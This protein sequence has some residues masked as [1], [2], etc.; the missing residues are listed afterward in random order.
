MVSRA[1][2][3]GC[4][5][6]FFEKMKGTLTRHNCQNDTAKIGQAQNHGPPH[7][8]SATVVTN[9]LVT[10]RALNV[11]AG[12][13]AQLEKRRID[14][15]GR[16]TS[17]KAPLPLSSLMRH[18][19]FPTKQLRVRFWSTHNEPATRDVLPSS[20]HPQRSSRTTSSTDVASPPQRATRRRS[21]KDA[22]NARGRRACNN[23]TPPAN[24]SSFDPVLQDERTGLSFSAN[25]NRQEPGSLL[26][27]PTEP[28]LPLPTIRNGDTNV[29][30]IAKCAPCHKVSPSATT[31]KSHPS[32]LL[33]ETKSLSRT[34]M[35]VH[36]RATLGTPV[37][38]RTQVGI[39]ISPG[40]VPPGTLHD[41]GQTYQAGHIGRCA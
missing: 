39:P 9:H 33:W 22:V 36:T 20:R 19:F 40:P 4:S 10:G 34:G 37:Q 28:A 11:R 14:S 30:S 13:A 31:S 38:R 21:T 7:G 15:P 17:W 5:F 12:G 41:D 32:K 29:V 23:C 8:A 26:T 2:R 1:S 3:C 18:A 24:V 27:P 25:Q 16:S 35:F 6:F